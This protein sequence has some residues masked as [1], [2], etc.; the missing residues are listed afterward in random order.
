M[1]QPKTQ[2]IEHAISTL[3]NQSAE[4]RGL[5]ASG[6]FVGRSELA[7][8]RERA[9]ALESVAEWLQATYLPE[10]EDEPEVEATE[11]ATYYGEI[12]EDDD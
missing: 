4:I 9:S 2:E 5:S 3:Q 10:E 6:F 8:A 7:A 12:E 11:Q 1:S